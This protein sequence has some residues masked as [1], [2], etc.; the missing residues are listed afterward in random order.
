LNQGWPSR[1]FS[2]GALPFCPAEQAR[3]V[4]L[5]APL[6][7]T[8]SWRGGTRLGPQAILDASRNMELYEEETGSEPHLAGI[9][10]LPEPELPQ[11][12]E[13]A[14]EM[15]QPICREVMAAGK[16]LVTLGGEHTVSLAP[17]RAAREVLGEFS[18]LQLDAH[19]DLR[20]SYL[21]DPLSH[22]CTMR[23]ARELAPVV[24]V[25]IRSLSAEEAE[26][27]RREG[28]QPFWAR[29]LQGAG[30]Q[31]AVIDRLS[32]RV[33]VTIDLDVF[34]PAVMPAVGTPEPG[35]LGWYPVLSLLAAV[36]AQRQVVGFDV[37]ELAPLP[38][39]VASDFLAARL[40]YKFLAYLLQNGPD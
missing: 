38:G 4:V 9:H 19:A 2:F 13:A 39:Q 11:D 24:G 3:V 33:Y 25:G 16:L 18:I 35:G 14:L 1:P 15:L 12:P 17:I 36:A 20:D 30:W 21:G 40:T 7:A 34:D 28:T 22:A 27:M 5:P 26:F 37:V 29:D 8:V 10:T 31:Q 32:P 6:E 23:R